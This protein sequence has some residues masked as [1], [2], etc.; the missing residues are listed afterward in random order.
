MVKATVLLGAGASIDAGL[1]SAFALTNR[2]YD[3]LRTTGH[4]TQSVLFG[5]IISKL[6]SRRVLAGGSPF[7]PINVEEAYDAILRLLDRDR[8]VIAEFVYSWDPI[9]DQ[10]KPRF[11]EDTFIKGIIEGIQDQTRSRHGIMAI[12]TRGLRSSAQAVSSALGVRDP[13]EG[14]AQTA[15]LY[16]DILVKLL[17]KPTG[18]TDY[19][20]LLARFCGASGSSLATLNYDLLVEEAGDRQG[21]KWDYG[22]TTWSANKLVNWGKEGNKLFKLHGSLNWSGTD[23]TISVSPR[24]PEVS[25]WTRSNA[26]LIFGG[27]SGK[28]TARGPFLQLRHEFEREILRSNRLLIIGYSFGDDHVNAILRRWVSTRTSAKMV[29]IEPGRVDFGLDVFRQSYRSAPDEIRKIIDIVLVRKTARSGMSEALR[30]LS[31]RIDLRHDR[32][33]NGYLPHIMVKVID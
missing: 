17:S 25:R 10:L 14:P 8:D 26:L 28:L 19:I 11:N 18:E 23:D 31:S 21:V 13:G 2:V 22:L 9:L 3:E 20:D 30:Q 16:I 33:K 7:D 32:H 15:S 1:P 12:N 5:Y 4:G 29:I 27:Q 24:P 6:I